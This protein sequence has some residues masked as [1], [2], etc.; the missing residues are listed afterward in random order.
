MNQIAYSS[1]FIPPEWIAAHGL[2]PVWHRWPGARAFHA[3]QCAAACVPMPADCCAAEAGLSAAAIVMATTC[4]QMRR[5]A[6]EVEAHGR[7]PCFLLNV[8]ATWQTAA[9][10]DLYRRE[11]ERLGRFLERI[12]GQARSAARLTQVMLDY[13]RARASVR[14]VSCRGSARQLAEWY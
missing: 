9:A 6:A 12:G 2:Q 7:V 13:D 3:G 14:T 4:D 8:P 1:P 10:R 5:L 11:I